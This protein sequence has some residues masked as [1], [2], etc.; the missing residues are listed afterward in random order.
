MEKDDYI[1]DQQKNVKP[2]NKKIKYN[3]NN[4]SII[5]DQSNNS[6][7]SM[8]ANTYISDLIL[9]SNSNTDSENKKRSYD[10]ALT[11]NN[12]IYDVVK[13]IKISKNNTNGNNKVYESFLNYYK[14]H[15]NELI[16]KDEN[17][18]PKDNG[19]VFYNTNVSDNFIY[20]ENNKKNGD[21]SDD[22]F[23]FNENYHNNPN[24]NMINHNSKSQDN[25]EDDED[26]D[27]KEYLGI[28]EK[29]KNISKN[30]FSS[31]TKNERS[32]NGTVVIIHEKIEYD[33]FYE[34][35]N[36]IVSHIKKET[37]FDIIIDIIQNN[38]DKLSVNIYK[39]L[40]EEGIRVNSPYIIKTIFLIAKSID[41]R[42][43]LKFKTE[44]FQYFLSLIEYRDADLDTF[45]EIIEGL[46]S[47]GIIPPALFV[48][49]ICSMFIKFRCIDEVGMILD[50]YS[51]SF[52][53]NKYQKK[54]TIHRMISI[55]LERKLIPQAY[56]FFLFLDK[57]EININERDFVNLGSACINEKYIDSIIFTHIT[58]LASKHIT[59]YTVIYAFWE[60]ILVNCINKNKIEQAI[61][62]YRKLIK[63]YIPSFETLKLYLNFS[64]D[65]N[66]MNDYMKRLIC[67]LKGLTSEAVKQISSNCLSS[68]FFN[69]SIKCCIEC[70]YFSHAMWIFVFMN[71]H[72]IKINDDIYNTL[73]NNYDKLK[74]RDLDD[75]SES[76]V[77]KKPQLDLDSLTKL[78]VKFY[79]LK[80]YNISCKFLHYIKSKSNY[81]CKIDV[82][83]QLNVLLNDDNLD[84]AYNLFLSNLNNNNNNNN[85]EALE[86]ESII[87]LIEKLIIKNIGKNKKVQFNNIWL[88]FE[89]L[90]KISSINSINLK[91]LFSLT[92]LVVQEKQWTKG[93]EV[94]KY[95]NKNQNMLIDRSNFLCLFR[96]IEKKDIGNSRKEGFVIALFIYCSQTGIINFDK[97][98]IR[99]GKLV[100][101]EGL[102]FSIVR[103]LFIQAIEYINKNHPE[104]NSN[105]VTENSNNLLWWDKEF[106]VVLP[107]S[108]KYKNKNIGNENLIKTIADEL[109]KFNPPYNIYDESNRVEK[110]FKKLNDYNEHSYEIILDKNYLFNWIKII[111][112]NLYTVFDIIGTSPPSNTFS[113]LTTLLVNN[114]YKQHI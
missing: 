4:N 101:E 18:N 46:K 10:F 5:Q 15:P 92:R 13:R 24:Y 100:I 1:Y 98:G 60:Q 89:Y 6:D 55:L 77:N 8:K 74:E 35:E 45:K 32:N 99:N 21:F 61:M 58:N 81:K 96:T 110:I 83:I 84:D 95:F 86:Q 34:F 76:I 36:L 48:I 52:L 31:D 53:N 12:E 40:I 97:E 78:T 66:N 68:S 39:R 20:E 69:D 9:G 105:S 27:E 42:E 33:K 107:S 38:V 93:M 14:N 111:N 2:L 50:L 19:E 22:K 25:D 28:E 56:N 79:Q 23:L 59:E 113:D 26:D 17:N 67:N 112:S 106:K 47:S 88:I 29:A 51:I 85:N 103:L 114:D 91:V 43:N 70:N 102:T 65:Y 63:Y 37:S 16:S 71:R 90:K 72:N 49:Y 73:L 109:N 80:K 41:D 75:I 3:N 30:L 94:L 11:R 57:N 44:D 104:L 108:I 7:N 82:N 54:Q 64:M 87:K 62:I